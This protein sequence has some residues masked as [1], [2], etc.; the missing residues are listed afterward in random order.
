MKRASWW[1]MG[2][3]VLAGCASTAPRSDRDVRGEDAEVAVDGD[4]AEVAVDGDDADVAMDGDAPPGDR[5]PSPDREVG[6][7]DAAPDAARDAARDASADA[8]LDRPVDVAADVALDRAPDVAADV[9]ADRAPD[10]SMDAGLDAGADAGMDAP[11]DLGL[12]RPG[13]ATAEAFVCVGPDAAGA[14]ATPSGPGAS[15]G[16]VDCAAAPRYG[17]S[18]TLTNERPPYGDFVA[19]PSLHYVVT[20]LAGQTLVASATNLSFTARA[21]VLPSC[22]AG[23]F[24]TASDGATPGV[25]TNHTGAS[26][27]AVVRVEFSTNPAL[28]SSA[29][30]SVTLLDPVATACASLPRLA[31][32]GSLSGL[33]LPAAP[34]AS[35]CPQQT[36]FPVR[37]G[38]G[39]RQVVL[40]APAGQ[41][42]T[43]TATSASGVPLFLTARPTCATSLC[44][45]L[46]PQAAPTA[47]LLYENTSGRDRDLVVEV[48]SATA[49]AASTFSLR[50]DVPARADATCA[51][52]TGADSGSLNPPVRANESLRYECGYLVAAQLNYTRVTV[53]VGGTV[54]TATSVS[55][56]PS[57]PGSAPLV[58][59]GC[60]GLCRDDVR[61][62]GAGGVTRSVWAYRT[63]VTDAVV[64]AVPSPHPSLPEFVSYSTGVVADNDRCELAAELPVPR[65][66]EAYGSALAATARE[67]S[68]PCLT[69][70]AERSLYY[71]VTIPPRT[72]LSAR[73]GVRSA[74]EI[75]DRCGSPCARLATSIRIN[76]DFDHPEAGSSV[77]GVPNPNDT[78]RTVILRVT[79]ADPGLL[80]ASFG[81]SP[82]DAS[83]GGATP[84][85]AGS[86]TPVAG[87]R[88]LLDA[89]APCCFSYARYLHHFRTT[90]PPGQWLGARVA[91][92]FFNHV[93]IAAT[94]ASTSVMAC[95]EGDNIA[96]WFNPGPSPREVYLRAG[97]LDG[98]AYDEYLNTA[99]QL[100]TTLS[101]T[102]P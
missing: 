60:D 51:A 95:Q 49:D 46:L 23:S 11:A 80:T 31:V 47:T 12:D 92:G 19:T 44:V 90:V 9:A 30:L 21:R 86:T 67:A 79:G 53:P 55:G 50:A 45:G 54:T 96:R 72:W 77:V 71:R 28:P 99:F 83:C 29:D 7:D 17:R 6:A 93:E 98:T 48:A 69:G 84:I 37:S 34:A 14:D 100:V 91:G 81:T 38:G 65:T 43:V 61:Y 82:P 85:T 18:F 40:R 1:A 101:A 33:T 42:L 59:D 75:Y 74:L 8:A 2:V 64:L 16:T 102:R 56:C 57:C 35:L 58:L 24:W 70:A 20:L 4:D 27:D 89:P 76:L 73:T 66:G 26:V 63:G 97:S 94:C 3:L 78:P 5:E 87:N 88:P 52:S 22:G 25:W 10:A 62:G 68:T 32:G 41:R 15:A 36:S 13:D 39:R